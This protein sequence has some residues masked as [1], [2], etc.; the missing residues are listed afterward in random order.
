MLV[1]E[2]GEITRYTKEN[3]NEKPAKLEL[4]ATR[5][6]DVFA[7]VRRTAKSVATKQLHEQCFAGTI[8]ATGRERV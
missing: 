3:L 2:M 5:S 8:C 4:S 6:I 7:I 1:L